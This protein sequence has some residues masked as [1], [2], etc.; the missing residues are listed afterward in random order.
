MHRR[1]PFGCHVAIGDVAPGIHMKKSYRGAGG[2]VPLGGGRSMIV[3]F[4]PWFCVMVSMVSMVGWEEG[5]MGSIPLSQYKQQRRMTND[6]VVLVR[7]LD[8]TSLTVMWHLASH[9]V[10]VA[11]ARSLGDVAFLCHSGRGLEV[12]SVDGGGCS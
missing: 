6:V 9:H 8:A 1:L 4:V 2:V 3:V 11:R 10:D 7:R 12:T 5:G